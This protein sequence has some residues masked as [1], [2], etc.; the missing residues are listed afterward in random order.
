MDRASERAE[1]KGYM[2]DLFLFYYFAFLI[3]MAAD[4]E[5]NTGILVRN[6]VY[7]FACC[8]LLQYR[9]S[10][11]GI[12]YCSLFENCFEVYVDKLNCYEIRYDI[13]IFSSFCY[14]R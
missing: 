6:R 14:Y 2:G 12:L 3:L 10:Q 1:R 8:C 5:G 11:F 7:L 9:Y 13:G 4:F